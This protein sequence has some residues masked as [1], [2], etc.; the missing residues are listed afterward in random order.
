GQAEFISSMGFLGGWTGVALAGII[1]DRTH[2][3]AAILIPAVAATDLGLA[4]GAYL[5][6]KAL[7][8]KWRG[9][10]ANL[11]LY[12][13]TGV[14]VGIAVSSLSS[15]ASAREVLG[16]VYPTS[17]AGLI[18]A[19]LLT[20]GYNTGEQPGQASIGSWTPTVLVTPSGHSA[21]GLAYAGAF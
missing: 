9:R 19:A 11:G 8:G 4:L 14:G 2:R 10:L 21:L 18:A 12:L 1:V 5:A 13:G 20:S 7:W 17:I 3:P 16:I 6:P 15:N